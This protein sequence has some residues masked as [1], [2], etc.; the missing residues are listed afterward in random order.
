[1]FLDVIIQPRLN[2]NGGLT[3]ELFDFRMDEQLHPIVLRGCD[4]LSVP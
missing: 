1:M 3:K 4:Y 2:F